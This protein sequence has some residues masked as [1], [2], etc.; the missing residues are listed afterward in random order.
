MRCFIVRIYARERPSIPTIYV[1]IYIDVD[2][3]L[4]LSI[5]VHIY[6]Y[7]VGPACDHETFSRYWRRI[8]RQ[9]RQ[10]YQIDNEEN[11]MPTTLEILETFIRLHRAAR[12]IKA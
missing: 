12:G 7:I 11:K 10:R 8:A 5:N 6:I 9:Q 1:Y 3:I 2:C 4:Y